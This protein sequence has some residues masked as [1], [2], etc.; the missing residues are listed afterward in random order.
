MFGYYKEVVVN[1]NKVG[2]YLFYYLNG[3]LIPSLIRF[4]ELLLF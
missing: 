3:A 1:Y 2:I 4:A